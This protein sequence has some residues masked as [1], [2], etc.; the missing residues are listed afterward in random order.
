MPNNLLR[1]VLDRHWLAVILVWLAAAVV[2]RWAAPGWD[3]I[4]Q[5][6]DLQH[7]PAHAASVQAER[8]SRA[9]F[10]D[11]EV[12]S[13]LVLVFARGSGELTVEDRQFILDTAFQ[14]EQADGLPV[15]DVWHEKT[16]L[17]HRML[18]APG[19]HAQIVVV[20]LTNPLM[21]VDNV[22]VLDAVDALV[23][24]RMRVAPAGLEYGVTGSAAIG[25]D[26]FK[27][28]RESLRATHSMTLLLVLACLAIIYRAPLL[29]VIPLFTIIVATSV[30]FSLIALSVVAT[31]G[32]AGQGWLNVFTTTR[33]IVVVVLFG[34]GTD[35][36]L[37]LIS[38]YREV[39][40]QGVP[41][42][43]APG[44]A[45]DAVATALLG[46]A[47]TSIVGLGVMGFAQYGKYASGGPVIAVSLAVAVAACMTLAPA[48]LRL[49]GRA[50][51]W[52]ARLAPAAPIAA[53]SA[54]QQFWRRVADVVCRRPY[55]V[56]A[57][58]L[59]AM[60]P[61]ALAGLRVPVNYDL[62]SEIPADSRSV[63]GA[64]LVSRHFG[65][66]WLAPTRVVVRKQGG[67]LHDPANRFDISLLHAALY[68]L[69]QVRDVRS[70]YLPAGGAPSRQRR[71]SMA[72]IYTAAA[73][74]SPLSIQTFVSQTPPLEGDVMELSLVLRNNPFSLN[75]RR[76][77]EAIRA[78]LT[79]FSQA[80]RYEGRPNPWHGA[81]FY[82]A[83]VAPGMRDLALV[84]A[85]D[86]RR[87]QVLT[88]LAVLT[89]LLVVIRRPLTCLYLIA[90]V[91][92][93][94]WV[95]IGAT[96]MAFQWLYG[97]AFVGLNWKAPLFLFVILIAVGQDY[98]VYL[99][100]RILEEQRRSGPAQGLR[101]AI[102]GTGAV[103]TGCGVIMAGTFASLAMG[104]LGGM[105]Q[106]GVALTVGVLLDT[107]V[108]RTILVPCYFAI[109]LRAHG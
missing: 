1:H 105:V 46:S 95:S 61:F 5:E 89:V 33:V 83:G 78:F 107:F 66:G 74:G 34:A 86:Q 108:V 40:Q 18:M 49:G 12:Q 91:L 109:R 41:L 2:L 58:C 84:T 24:E 11:N 92:L 79:Q 42:Q 70:A 90:T 20:R 63:K 47:L 38:R 15:V 44:V 101:D 36:C 14:V 10:P 69:P 104:T 26:T 102:S 51:F 88:V 13:E 62:L 60:A 54:S 96:S 19:G 103:I 100:T 39:L 65:R 37:F 57:F 77:V 76:D 87:I 48:L 93:S 97:D 55:R 50:V 64:E 71:F 106:L 35:Y 28:T 30:A 56:L 43:A 81:R 59:A 82:L 72:G 7:L 45:L 99:V 17:V 85:S 22:R 6:G 32:G 94:Y 31:G 67:Q 98:N 75:A 29:V 9:A 3:Q 53:P 21:S 27:A 80:P 4:T 73:S 23:T 52:P 16:P 25:G 68:Q 8:L